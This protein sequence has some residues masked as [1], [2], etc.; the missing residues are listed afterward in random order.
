MCVCVCWRWARRLRRSVGQQCGLVHVTTMTVMGFCI[1]FI[2]QI[3]IS[4]ILKTL[5]SLVPHA[6]V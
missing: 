5:A 6:Q 2:T 3:L 4:L 1:G